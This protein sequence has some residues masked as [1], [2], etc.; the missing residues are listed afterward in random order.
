M[1]LDPQHQASFNVQA[2]IR[3]NAQEQND[4]L[5][6]MGEWE[7]SIKIKDKEVRTARIAKVR[8]MKKANPKD[9]FTRIRES[10]GTVKIRQ[11]E[12][13]DFKV[14]FFSSF[15]TIKYF[16]RLPYFSLNR[17]PARSRKRSTARSAR[18]LSAV[19]SLALAPAILATGRL[20]L[21][22]SRRTS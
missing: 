3:R 4:F 12:P 18:M 9:A 21:R 1:A 6:S 22:S 8:E 11:A 5:K 14:S 19:Y 15:F 2:Q 7:K 16:L 10:G 17:Y 13:E 20:P